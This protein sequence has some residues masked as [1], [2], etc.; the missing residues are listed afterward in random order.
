MDYFDHHP[1][2]TPSSAVRRNLLAEDM[3]L[4]AKNL[5]RHKPLKH[6]RASSWYPPSKDTRQY[7]RNDDSEETRFDMPAL[8]ENRLLKIQARILK[9]K[10]YKE[11]KKRLYQ[12][13]R[14]R[15]TK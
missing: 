8:G 11:T 2:Q 9:S 10:H 4:G 15:L 5:I 6:L 14:Q 3:W 12:I 1:A 7:L 13:R